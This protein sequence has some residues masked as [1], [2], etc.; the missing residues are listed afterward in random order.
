MANLS[1]FYSGAFARYPY[2]LTSSPG[3]LEPRPFQRKS[4]LDS[5]KK[6]KHGLD[7]SLMQSM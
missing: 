3:Q 4:S 7:P 6:V 2:F 1:S 5:P